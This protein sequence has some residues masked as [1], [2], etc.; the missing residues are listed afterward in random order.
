MN[1][2]SR[3]LR[4]VKAGQ[5]VPVFVRESV[6]DANVLNPTR[7][8][9]AQTSGLGFLPDCNSIMSL[10]RNKQPGTFSSRQPLQC[11]GK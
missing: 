8:L 5:S 3:P 2:G 1:E 11:P 7:E 4:G 6:V 10:P 9:V